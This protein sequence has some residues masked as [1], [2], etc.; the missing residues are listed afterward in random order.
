[1]EPILL[2][3]FKKEAAITKWIQF[4]EPVLLNG[5]DFWEPILKSGVDFWEQIEKSRINFTMY[6]LLTDTTKIDTIWE[7]IKN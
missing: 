6:V 7:P 3:S 1:L 2:S 4:R 5:F